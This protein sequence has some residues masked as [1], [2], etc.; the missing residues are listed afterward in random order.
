MGGSSK[1]QTVGYKYYVGVHMIL[2]H[3]P[4]DR[5]IRVQVDERTAWQGNQSGSAQI[6]I[7]VP[8]LFGG[9]SREGGIQGTMDFEVG[10]LTQGKNSYLLS[11]LGSLI[12]A[13]RGVAGVVLRQMY[14]GLNPYLKTW[15]FR[16]SRVHTRQKGIAQWYDA[17][18]EILSQAD[19]TEQLGPTSSGWK[20]KVVANGAGDDYSSPSYDDSSWPSGQ[21]PFGNMGPH[22]YAGG[23]GFPSSP[24]T[25]WAIN[26]TIWV[27]RKFN[28]QTNATFNLVIFVDNY[29][30]VWVNG[31]KVLDRSGTIEGPSGTIFTHA[32]SVPANILNVGKNI[33]VLKAED[34]GS[35]SYAAFKLDSGNL[36]QYDMNPAHIIRECLTDPDWGMGYQDADIDDTS[37]MAA[38]DKLFEEG[39]GMSLMWDTQTSIEEFIKL[40]VKHIDAALYV[41]RQSGKFVLKL[42]R[43]DFDVNTLI[44]L[45]KSNI[46][47]IADFSRPSFGELTN[48][49]TVTYW[50]AK[51]GA[52]STITVQ[53]IALQQMQG[54]SIGTSISYP[55]FTNSAIA[56]RVAQR[57]L[58][59]LSTPLISCTIYANRDAA[60]L[61]IGK[62]FRFTWP[63]YDVDDV[64]MRVTGIAYGDGK[65]NRIRLQ[66]VQDIF[67]LPNVA[68]VQPSPPA[69][70]DPSQPPLP[71]TVRKTFEIPYLE[72]VQTVGKQDIDTTLS[73]TPEVGYVG[74]AIARPG[75]E[76]NARMWDD[77]GAGYQE[78]G[79][80]DFSP[81]AFLDGAIS[82]MTTTFPIKDGIDLDQVVLN[83]WAQID[84]E[85]V[86]V[87]ALTASSITVKRGCLDTTPKVHADGAALVFWDNYAQGDNTELVSSDIAKVKVV[88]VSGAGQLDISQAPEDIITIV[89]RAARPYPPANVRV[90]SSYFPTYLKAEDISLQWVHRDRK[91]QTASLVGFTEGSIGPESGTTYT[92]E[93][94]DE[95]NTLRRTYSAI[96]GTSQSWA[97]EVDDSGLFSQGA[98]QYHNESFNTQ[99]P[100][101]YGLIRSSGGTGQAASFDAST[102]AMFLDANS[103]GTYQNYYEITS[104]PFFYDL[105]FEVDMECVLDAYT[106]KHFGLWLPSTTQ[107]S[108][109]RIA[110]GLQTTQA[111]PWEFSRWPSGSWTSDV[112]LTP[113]NNS[114]PSM[115]L[116]ER[117]RLRVTWSAAD[118]IFRFYVDGALIYTVTDTTYKQL[119]PGIFFYQ[120]KLRIHEITVRGHTVSSRYNNKVNVVLKSVRSSLSSYQPYD[121]TITRVGYGYSYGLS[122]GGL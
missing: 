91:Q 109:Y 98:E 113:G 21:S 41:D 53:D 14:M 52:D 96:S 66:C 22:P 60:N 120:C 50:N 70:K 103:S 104:L 9:E 7:N 38:A 114:N 100:S 37:F 101:S 83:T 49:V 74:A 88:T 69:W 15:S 39:M 81:A 61:N 93:M 110:H 33:L 84:D 87:T 13:F 18:A 43:A 45:D 63:D 48:S 29:A 85:I 73:A 106:F 35:Y 78:V 40:I 75:N 80:I 16:I 65:T 59:T 117:R 122:Y 30:T 28:L 24:N 112:K 10:S 46:D 12:P 119:R 99:I 64:V 11:K 1:S 95:G 82:Q 107:P 72:L 26:S 94:K 56:T 67:S 6:S 3:G 58:R 89:G 118:G 34:Y 71:A 23:A 36:P 8:N 5:L 121:Y 79:N 4:V 62:C 31:V 54:A 102:G 47:K 32:I 77:L 105:D 20:Y 44:V 27:R 92:V 86:A 51:T 111:Y 17:K 97:T 68:F 57:D 76:I 115:N 116:N 55:G 2:S 90:N 25:T 108:G 19:I 42:I